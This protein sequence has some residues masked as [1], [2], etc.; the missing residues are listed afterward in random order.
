MSARPQTRGEEIAN[1]ISHG[2]GALAALASA[3]VL[4]VHVAPHG[5]AAAIVGTVVFAVT[6]VLLYAASA[7][8]HALPEGRAK[9]IC[10]TLDHCA[11]YLFIAGSYTPFA[12]GVLS[13]A[14]GWTLFGVVWGLAS[15]GITLKIFNRLSHPI[16]STALYLAMGWLVVVAAPLFARIATSGL[17]WLLAG[18]L[19]YTA[20]V[21]FFLADNRL[22]FGHFVWHL[23]VLAGSAFH[24]VA[25]MGYAT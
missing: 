13:G 12:L 5:H 2:V 10:G 8:Y 22:R 3:P 9:E 18:G 16:V 7:L 24:F 6:M 20:G 1:S 4:I 23:F 21:A 19:A 17:W 11:I 15:L 25:V 14:W